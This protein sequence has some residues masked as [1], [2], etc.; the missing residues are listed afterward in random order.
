MF[1]FSFS[2][3]FADVNTATGLDSTQQTVYDTVVGP[4]GSILNAKFEAAWVALEGHTVTG[5]EGG[6]YYVTA[7]AYTALKADAK[8]ALEKYVFDQAKLNASASTLISAIDAANGIRD[9]IDAALAKE[10]AQ[11]QFGIDY[12]KEIAKLDTVDVTAYSTEDYDVDGNYTHQTKAA[13]LIAKAKA[14]AAVYAAGIDSEST[15]YDCAVAMIAVA[16][17]ISDETA[18]EELLQKVYFADNTFTGTYEIADSYGLVKAT[19]AAADKAEKEANK[20]ALKALAAKYVAA[21]QK[22]QGVNADK[23][24][25][26]AYTEMYNVRIDSEACDAEDEVYEVAG[27]ATT[28]LEDNYEAVQKVVA[29]AEKCKAEKDADGNLVRNA[30]AIDKIVKNAKKAAYNESQNTAWDGKINGVDAID[31]IKST[32]VESTAVG[33]EYAKTTAK[34]LI[35]EFVADNYYYPAEMAKVNALVEE[36]AAKVDAATK[37]DEITNNVIGLYT[38][39]LT[40]IDAVQEKQEVKDAIDDKASYAAAVSALESYV[41]YYNSTLTT[42]AEAVNK[43]DEAA[44]EDVLDAF[45]GEA[46]ARTEAELKALKGDIISLVDQLPTA[47]EQAAAKKAAEAAID[48]IPA[49]VTLADEATI[50][51]A[52]DAVNAYTKLQGTELAA[53][54][55]DALDA[56]RRALYNAYRLD[57]NKKTVAVSK[58]DKAALKALQAEFKAA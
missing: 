43:L 54:Y 19:T 53:K 7:A 6:S 27:F 15:V 5:A 23:D 18:S 20:A 1:T 41:T 55:T 13:A 39:Y 52:V 17:I 16:D 38:T 29:Y 10:L 26:A 44:I 42:V 47:G 33:L 51:A 34:T 49:V 3:A 58:T 22:A 8:A 56:A 45:Y 12:A 36:F 9:I 14:D 35:N 48:A 40:K 57:L 50:K 2:T 4:S 11:A 30:E 46:G 24:L 25:I 21:Y 31:L 37:T 32:T 28:K